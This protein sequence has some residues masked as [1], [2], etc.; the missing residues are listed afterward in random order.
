MLDR[1]PSQSRPAPH[2]RLEPAGP[3]YIRIAHSSDSIPTNEPSFDWQS[4]PTDKLL[5]IS[6]SLFPLFEGTS[7]LVT[8]LNTTWSDPLLSFVINNRATTNIIVSLISVF[9]ASLSVYTATKLINL[10]VRTHFMEHSL[11]LKVISFIRAISTSSLA[12]G[13]PAAMPVTSLTVVLA[14]TL[15]YVLWTGALTPILTNAT[16]TSSVHKRLHHS[17]QQ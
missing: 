7:L 16:T 5:L 10:A 11:T 17:N 9:L 1:A 8:I 6:A 15:P 13:I 2:D 12:G 14:F 4:T 3:E